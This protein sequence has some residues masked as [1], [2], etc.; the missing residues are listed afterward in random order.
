VDDCVAILRKLTV[1]DDEFFGSVLA[2]DEKNVAVSGLDART[3]AFVRLGAMIALDAPTPAYHSSIEAALRAGSS[4]EEVVGALVAV[5][6]TA[7]VA[8]V[9]S[10]APKLGLAV[11]YD[12]EAALESLDGESDER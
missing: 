5:I 8:R 7:G 11:G 3:H 2:D 4:L 10:A 6:P 9:A 12:V 1:R